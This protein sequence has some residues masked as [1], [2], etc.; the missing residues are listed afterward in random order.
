[1]LYDFQRITYSTPRRSL[2]SMGPL[3]FMDI[4]GKIVAN[5]SS[6]CIN[7]T[8]N[9]CGRELPENLLAHPKVKPSIIVDIMKP[10]NPFIIC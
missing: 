9:T 5:H 6:L 2:S 7:F 4:F 8:E 1:M 3:M 10:E